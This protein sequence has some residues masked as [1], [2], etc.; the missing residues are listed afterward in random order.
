VFNFGDMNTARY[1]AA[2]SSSSTR[3]ITGGGSTPTYLNEIEYT[4][5]ASEGN[6]IDFG[7]LN[8]TNMSY[9]AGC[10]SS[11]RGMFN[12]GYQSSPA[13]HAYLNDMN[14]VEIA[15]IGNALDFAD[16]YMSSYAFGSCSSPTRGFVAGG[17]TPAGNFQIQVYTIAEKANT[18]HFGDL[19]VARFDFYGC[20][21]STRGVF[22]GGRTPSVMS[23]IDYIT[24]ASEGNAI[25]FGNLQTKS[26]RIGAC[27]SQTRGLWM[28]GYFT[29]GINYSTIQYVTFASLGDA[30][31]FGDLNDPPGHSPGAYS[32]AHGGLGGF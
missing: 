3:G 15:T 29:G 31:D 1:I 12:A 17:D 21:S 27:G 25:D 20:S 19:S 2:S 26:F 22:G 23:T 4:T 28:G 13:P 6:G 30:I 16:L 9:T 8:A 32:N 5:I 11:T 14:Y 18:T 10:S 7:D 24:M